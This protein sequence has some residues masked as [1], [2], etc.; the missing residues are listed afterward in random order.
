[1]DGSSFDMELVRF[2][3]HQQRRRRE[4][5]AAARREAAATI[6]IP[7]S[8]WMPLLVWLSAAGTAILYFSW[9]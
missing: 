9:A 6:S 4:E 5:E 8:A 1:M 7:A 2:E 3:L